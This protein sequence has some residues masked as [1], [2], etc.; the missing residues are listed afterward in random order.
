MTES[1]NIVTEVSEVQGHGHA[2][3]HSHGDDEDDE[4]DHE[5]VM[6]HIEGQT[7]ELENFR[8]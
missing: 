3:G 4:D 8:Q 1:S 2:H 7:E 5:H 6:S